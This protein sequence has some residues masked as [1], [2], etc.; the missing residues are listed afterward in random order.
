MS[1]DGGSLYLMCLCTVYM[2]LFVWRLG[3]L[4][5]MDVAGC[6]QQSKDRVLLEKRKP[7]AL[8]HIFESQDSDKIR[9]L[10]K[11]VTVTCA[12]DCDCW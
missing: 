6:C 3:A 10:L 2:N 4:K 12:Y 11:K 5:A 8:W 7:G 1:Y 9:D